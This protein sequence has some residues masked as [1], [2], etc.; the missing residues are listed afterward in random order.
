[1]LMCVCVYIYAVCNLISSEK[2]NSSTYDEFQDEDEEMLMVLSIHI[3]YAIQG[4]HTSSKNFIHAYNVGQFLTRFLGK[5]KEPRQQKTFP[6]TRQTIEEKDRIT[7][8]AHNTYR[9]KQ[10]KSPF[11]LTRPKQQKWFPLALYAHYYC[12]STLTD[13]C[14]CPFSYMHQ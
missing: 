6:K 3:M 9:H 2:S 5:T 7:K 8:C 11:K 4:K 13:F 10:A 14:V 12:C 1:M